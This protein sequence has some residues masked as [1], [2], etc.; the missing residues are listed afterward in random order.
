MASLSH[1]DFDSVLSMFMSSFLYLDLGSM[2]N[3][4][5]VTF[6]VGLSVDSLVNSTLRSMHVALRVFT[7]FLWVGGVP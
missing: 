5:W 1:L 6:V 4:S 7:D 2:F 3:I